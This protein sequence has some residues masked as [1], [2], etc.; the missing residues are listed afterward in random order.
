MMAQQDVTRSGIGP[1]RP[2]YRRTVTL[3]AVV[4]KHV[5]PFSSLPY[6]APHH[7]RLHTDIALRKAGPG[8]RGSSLQYALP[9]I[10]DPAGRAGSTH[11][12]A[13]PV[14]PTS[15]IHSRAARLLA[16]RSRGPLMCIQR[17]QQ[18]GHL[19]SARA[20]TRARSAP[21]SHPPGR[22]LPSGPIRPAALAKAPSPPRLAVAAAHCSR[23]RATARPDTPPR[24]C[25]G[26]L[27]AVVRAGRRR[28]QWATR[29]RGRAGRRRRHGGRRRRRRS[30]RDAR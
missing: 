21:A 10:C 4:A 22:D 29:Q 30:L 2:I 6:L 24:S 5:P 17:R 11:S 12:K 13:A 23:A 26:G 16:A 15:S 7:L 27:A 9:A 3:T 18:Q 19:L 25:G 14:E 28:D 20:G 8:R 1:R